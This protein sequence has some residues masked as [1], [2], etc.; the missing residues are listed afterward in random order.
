MFFGNGKARKPV[1]M[2]EIRK[3]KIQLLIKVGYNLPVKKFSDL[4]SDVYSTRLESYIYPESYSE[5][6]FS[7][8]GVDYMIYVAPQP[9]G[10][11]VGVKVRKFFYR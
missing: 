3:S 7:G 8:F 5:F 2:T 6:Y 1:K 11:N 9:W 4:N 10:V